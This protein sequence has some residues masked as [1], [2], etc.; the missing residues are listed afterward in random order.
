MG[1][2]P[3]EPTAD[4]TL[5][6]VPN[7]FLGALFGVVDLGALRGRLDAIATSSAAEVVLITASGAPLLAHGTTP[8][9][10]RRPPVAA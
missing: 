3:S 4:P 2:R 8:E 1:Q 10:N 5:T 7:V 9:L 6:A